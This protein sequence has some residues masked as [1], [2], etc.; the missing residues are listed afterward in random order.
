MT[1]DLVIDAKDLCKSFKAPS[2]IELLKNLSLS[3]KRG[4]SIAIMGPSGVGK[5]TLLHI[6]GTLEKPSSGILQYFGNAIYSPHDLRA[7]NIGFIFQNYHLLED[8]TALENVLLPAK[9]SRQRVH[10]GSPA[11]ERAENLLQEVGLSDRS[12]FPVKKLSGGE[13]QRVCIARALCNDPDVLLADEPSGNLDLEN[14]ENIHKLLISCTKK[15]SKTLI[16]V[17]HDKN[18]AKLCDTVYELRHGKLTKI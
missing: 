9:I 5:S 2:S 13:K 10:K 14:S 3:A 12:H 11:Y 8:M 18:L 4:E 17:T 7:N 1:Q 6:L 16:A 15:Y